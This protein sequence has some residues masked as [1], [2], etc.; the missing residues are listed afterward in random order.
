L[1]V[2]QI[3]KQDKASLLQAGI[4]RRKQLA[5]PLVMVMF[6]V[7]VFVWGFS[8]KNNQEPQLHNIDYIE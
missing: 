1:F 8:H 4:F 7:L 3:Q 6:G 2:W 5:V